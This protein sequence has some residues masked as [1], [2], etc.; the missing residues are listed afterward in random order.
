MPWRENHS[1][2]WVFVSEVMLQQ[3][4]VNRVL[5]KFERFVRVLP[6]WETLASVD[7]PTLLQLWSGLGYNNRAIRLRQAAEEIVRKYE[8]ILPAD[9]TLLDVLPGIGH[10]TA[11]AI[12]T[13]AYN[14]P[15]L[16][17]ETNIRRVFLHHFFADRNNIADQ[18]LLPF[19]A[20]TLD[21]THPRQW[22]WAL[23]DYGTHLKK[24]IS[25]PNRR[26]KQYSKQSAFE[27]S[28]RQMRGEIVRRLT[29]KSS[30]Q[31]LM[32]DDRFDKAIAG[33]L[34]DGIIARQSDKYDLK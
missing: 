11:S 8:S 33:L 30:L 27:G 12:V 16:F 17:I 6:D 31:D 29:T 32:V 3:T 18:D 24:A 2:Y 20:D 10:A 21:T 13:Y 25:N 28:V 9:A 7:T 26:S 4:Q 1:P 5:P 14:I 23:M 15:T 22:Y 34:R 19:I